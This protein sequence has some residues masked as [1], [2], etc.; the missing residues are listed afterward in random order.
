MLRTYLVI[1]AAVIAVTIVFPPTDRVDKHRRLAC[2]AMVDID[3]FKQLNDDF[4]HKVGDVTLQKVAAVM[5][6]SIRDTDRIYRY[7]GEEFVIIF[8]GAGEDKAVLLAERVLRAV[9]ETPLTGD[10]LEPVGPVTISAALAL[11]P[12]NGTDIGDLITLADR[13]MYR[14]KQPGRNRIAVWDEDIRS[15]LE[16][17]V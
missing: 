3:H 6:Q 4:G 5:R 15:L 8:R 14:A 9:A 17:A 2:V 11:M 13:A 1:V 16:P 10:H 12:E 7:G